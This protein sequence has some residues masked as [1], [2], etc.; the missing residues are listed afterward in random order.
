[1]KIYFFL[2]QYR[3]EG[4]DAHIIVWI[5]LT[6]IGI[7]DSFTAQAIF[8]RLAPI[9]ASMEVIPDDSVDNSSK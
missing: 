6:A 5:S 1:M 4:L 2:F 7:Q 8:K 9:L 3:M